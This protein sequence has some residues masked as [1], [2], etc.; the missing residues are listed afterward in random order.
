VAWPN[1]AVEGD[2]AEASPAW[3]RV[4][5]TSSWAKTTAIG[6]GRAW[7]GGN[8]VSF[9]QRWRVASDRESDAA[10]GH[11]G[12]NGGEA[13]E[14]SDRGVGAGARGEARAASDSDSA[15]RTRDG[16]RSRLLTRTCA[17]RT[18]P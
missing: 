1:D 9:E 17:W 15:L 12:W 3:R 8:S 6:G 14:A 13:G 18:T 2:M 11:G 5:R 10:L 16:G 4:V 7:P